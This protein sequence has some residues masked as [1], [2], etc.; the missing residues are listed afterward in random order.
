MS[1]KHTPWLT[2]LLLASPLSFAAAPTQPPLRAVLEQPQTTLDCATPALTLGEQA[3]AA[4]FELYRQHDFAPLWRSGGRLAELL[5]QLEQLEDD[6][7]DPASYQLASLHRLGRQ[8]NGRAAHAECADLLASHAYLEALGHLAWGRL[9]RAAVEPLWHSPQVRP[10]PRP[11]LPTPEAAQGLDDLPATF[12]AARPQTAAY[13]DLRRAWAELRRQPLPAWEPIAAGPL[14]RP[15]RSDPRVPLL[16]R[17]LAAEGYLGESA[18]ASRR[19]EA[20]GERYD[21][22][23]VD[24]VEAF[25]RRHLLQ[26]D[27]V[28]GPA[29]LAELNAA[30]AARRAQVRVNLE[31]LRWL[32]R[33]LE[34][35]MVLVD[36]AGARIAFRRAGETIWQARTQVGR[37]ERPTPLLKSRI[38]HLT[39]NPTWTVPPTILR[40]DK[41]PEIRRDLG[42]LARNDLR[43]LDYQGNTLD[44]QL[45]DW[46]N[47]R[48][49]LL[50]QEAGPKNPLGRVAIRFPN[51][52]SVYLH[53]TPSQYLFDRLPRVFSSGCVRVEQ[54]MRLLDFLLEEASP[55]QRARF[56]EQLASG[57]TRDF[58]LPR[59]MPILLAYWT[60]EADADGRLRFR[61]D[62]YRHDPRI[63]AALDAVRP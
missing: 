12:A 63:L 3:R 19:A 61:P 46:S 62:I 13:R 49:V 40:E 2:I 25:Q 41:L 56:E 47:P 23:L 7:L 54:V 45:V 20:R 6:G 21:P 27:G 36:V 58:G 8:P 14:L 51:P 55:S 18:L 43:V 53:D 59:P 34:P 15:G 31:R 1:K 24:A 32:A 39:L 30:P 33:E 29:T 11:T 50:R 4:L 52:F 37:A 5:G 35:D 38:S 48:G 28:V 16:E 22:L 9:E 60:A 26:P 57:V 42:F 17:R 10:A 44:P